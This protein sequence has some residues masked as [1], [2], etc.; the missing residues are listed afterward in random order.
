MSDPHNTYGL[1]YFDK[2][3]DYGEDDEE[4]LEL[5]G[6]DKSCPGNCCDHDCEC[7]DCVRCS[8]NSQMKEDSTDAVAA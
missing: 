5:D 7:D 4:E 1:Q 3:A 8:R 2:L 6:F